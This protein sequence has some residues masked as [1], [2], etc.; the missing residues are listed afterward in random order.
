MSSRVADHA[1]GREYLWE[2]LCRKERTRIHPSY[3]RDIG[4]VS[5][6]RLK[7]QQRI[8]T[9]GELYQTGSKDRFMSE[10]ISL[11]YSM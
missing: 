7:H 1:E 8:E 10:K 5:T 9:L 11:N 4:V 3:S 2:N 6:L